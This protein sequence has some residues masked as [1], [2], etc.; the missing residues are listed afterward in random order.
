MKKLVSITGDLLTISDWDPCKS[1]VFVFR[2]DQLEGLI[3]YNPENNCFYRCDKVSPSIGSAR[4][5]TFTVE[6]LKNFVLK[7]MSLGYTFETLG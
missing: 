2:G 1:S 7:E 6:T 3:F 4:A 5:L